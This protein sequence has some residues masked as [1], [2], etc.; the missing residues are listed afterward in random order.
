MESKSLKKITMNKGSETTII[1][2]C[3]G[4]YHTF[5]IPML[6]LHQNNSHAN[7]LKSC[8]PCHTS[9]LHITVETS[10]VVF[11]GFLRHPPSDSRMPLIFCLVHLNATEL[12]DSPYSQNRSITEYMSLH[13]GHKFLILSIRSKIFALEETLYSLA[14]FFTQVYHNPPAYVFCRSKCTH[15]G[16]PHSC[17]CYFKTEYSNNEFYIYFRVELI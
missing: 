17:K 9:A 7:H 16:S 10:K 2:H 13:C 5:G 12:D 15:L 3:I 1:Q 4:S 11:L 8:F 14:R 6:Y